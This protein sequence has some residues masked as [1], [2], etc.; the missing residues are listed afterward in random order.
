MHGLR[1]IYY[2]DLNHFKW[3]NVLYLFAYSGSPLP[4][5]SKCFAPL[6]TTISRHIFH[7]SKGPFVCSAALQYWVAQR[8]FRL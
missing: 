2:V 6:A 7:F 3:Y 5:V 8:A 1:A 4:L